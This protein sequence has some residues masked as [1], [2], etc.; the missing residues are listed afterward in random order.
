MFA[1]LF[2]LINITAAFSSA[3]PTSP[4]FSTTVDIANTSINRNVDPNSN[5][6]WQVRAQT[7]TKDF[8]QGSYT[9]LWLNP[10]VCVD[11]N[12]DVKSLRVV[13]HEGPV[14][15]DSLNVYTSL[16]CQTGPIVQPVLSLE[17]H[18]KGDHLSIKLGT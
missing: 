7:F 10:D 8:C 17:C 12:A 3:L 2:T 1:Q 14:K 15:D 4:A 6:F 16:G 9:F 18:Q 5:T 11:F 13:G